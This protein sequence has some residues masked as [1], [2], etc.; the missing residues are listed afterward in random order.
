MAYPYTTNVG[1]GCGPCGRPAAVA[2][3]VQPT[4]SVAQPA[5]SYQPLPTVTAPTYMPSAQSSAVPVSPPIMVAAT[6]VS[7]NTNVFSPNGGNCGSTPVVNNTCNKVTAASRVNAAV[8][9]TS[10]LPSGTNKTPCITPISGNIYPSLAPTAYG[11]I[12]TPDNKN[13]YN[14]DVN[15]A[16]SG[17]FK[18]QITVTS[19]SPIFFGSSTAIFGPTPTIFD[20]HYVKVGYI[21]V[22]AGN[23]SFI[24]Q[25]GMGSGITTASQLVVSVQVPDETPSAVSGVATAVARSNASFTGGTVLDVRTIPVVFDTAVETPAGKPPAVTFVLDFPAGTV[26]NQGDTVELSYNLMYTQSANLR[27][28]SAR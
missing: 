14:N 28:V 3:Y 16:I 26:L 7:Q 22:W 4:V 17:T 24:T 6:G 11:G 5:V 8:V 25:S 27:T 9:A 21:I 20:N 15:N 18:P 12:V 10:C 23:I 1:G 13:T 2:A 19:N